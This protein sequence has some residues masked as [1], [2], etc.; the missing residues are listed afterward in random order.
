MCELFNVSIPPLLV[1]LRFTSL[2]AS[3]GNQHVG[4]STLA[5]LDLEVLSFKKQERKFQL[6]DRLPTGM[7]IYLSSRHLAVWLYAMY[8][9]I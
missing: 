6:I 5:S 3:P 9:G 8:V 7:Y 4:I 2:L 1:F